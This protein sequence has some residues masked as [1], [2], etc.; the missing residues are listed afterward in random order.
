MHTSQSLSLYIHIPF[1]QTLCTYCAFNTYAGLGTLVEP[2]VAALCREIQIVGKGAAQYT[3]HTVYFGGGTPSLLQPDQ[4]ASILESCR[5][6]FRTA[7][8]AEI[9][10]EANPDSLTLDRLRAFREAGINRLSLG[11]QSAHEPELRLFGRRHSFAEAQGGFELA[12][13]AGFN[14]IS[15]DLIY[16]A[17]RQTRASW[18]ETLERV[19]AWSPDHLSLYSLTIEPGT[20][21]G[22]QVRRGRIPEPDPNQ[23]AAMY[24]LACQLAARAGL[25]H[26]EISNWARPGHESRHNRQY[27]LNEPYLGLGPGAHG[28]AGG[29][30]YWT[31]SPV[32]LY[33]DKIAQGASRPFPFSP[34]LDGYEG[35]SRELE[36][37]ETTILR[38]RLVK[39]G[40]SRAAFNERYGCTV[41][42]LYGDTLKQLH[43]LGLISMRGDRIRLK[44][45]AYLISNQVFWRLLPDD[46]RA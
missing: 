22:V 21:L 6:G 44:R 1:C 43:Q 8:D 29:V 34:A 10:L 35:I 37:A 9:T 5:T 41:D 13:Q 36:M 40:L 45:R 42:N 7:Q 16:G 11:V 15:V 39:E 4:I 27:W 25:D 46:T 33:I 12:R 28:A 19:L 38:L 30:R 14:D 31:V 3:V 26:Y 24:D 20:S 2:F 23:A 17:P 32:Q 18:R